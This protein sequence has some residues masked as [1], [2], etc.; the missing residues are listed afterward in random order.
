MSNII[1]GLF[2]KWMVFIAILEL[3]RKTF[4]KSV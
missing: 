3:Q 4:W 1:K 2:F